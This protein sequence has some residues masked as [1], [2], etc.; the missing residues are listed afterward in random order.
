MNNDDVVYVVPGDG[1]CGSNCA[2]A[3]LFGD[4][5]YGRRLRLRMNKF[6]GK[7]I[8]H[9][10]RTRHNAQLKVRL[11]ENLDPEKK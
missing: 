3:F 9:I 1:A 8:I 10:M 5:K 7:H 6:M 11:S 2:A 4:E